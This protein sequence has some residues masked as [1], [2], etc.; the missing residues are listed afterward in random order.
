MNKI[1]NLRNKI[2]TL[3]PNSVASDT[4]THTT[5][6]DGVTVIKEEVNFI[7]EC[8]EEMAMFSAEQFHQILTASGGNIR[9]GSFTQ[10]TA[11]FRGQN[12]AKAN[13]DILI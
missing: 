7:E 1:Y 12:A 13:N 10:C 9:G 6:L 4:T 8:I 11:R 3:A 5:D 2:S